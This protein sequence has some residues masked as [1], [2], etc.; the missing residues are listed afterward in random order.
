ME[1]YLDQI[2]VLP[3][4]A[5]QGGK[6]AIGWAD[7]PY[8]LVIH[9]CRQTGQV[10]PDACA[11]WGLPRNMSVREAWSDFDY[12]DEYRIVDY[13]YDVYLALY[14]T[15]HGKRYWRVGNDP[16]RLSP[17]DRNLG[18]FG[19]TK[20]GFDGFEDDLQAAYALAEEAGINLDEPETWINPSEEAK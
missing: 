1:I 6:W 8:V 13:N 9:T 20:V 11:V 18:R 16:D 14:E 17:P 10:C 3:I 5:T 19:P 12:R 4:T 15:A 7:A 2:E